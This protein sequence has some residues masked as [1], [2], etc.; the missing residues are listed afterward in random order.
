MGGWAQ[1]LTASLRPCA[2]PQARPRGTREAARLSGT[3]RHR[4][5]SPRGRRRKHRPAPTRE[6]TGRAEHAGAGPGRAGPPSTGRR[7]RADLR[8]AAMSPPT[9]ASQAGPASS[10]A[11]AGSPASAAPA[12]WWEADGAVPARLLLW[13]PDTPQR[14]AARR[15]RGRP[16]PSGSPPARAREGRPRGR[17]GPWPPLWPLYGRPQ[18]FPPRAEPAALGGGCRNVLLPAWGFEVRASEGPPARLPAAARG[19]RRVPALR[20]SSEFATL[21]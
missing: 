1:L 4:P 6:A 7:R 10:G 11:A 12:D 13:E 9:A 14:S 20:G 17:P 3:L 21:H 19:R 2:A 18:E 16:A 8:H 5:L 15:Q